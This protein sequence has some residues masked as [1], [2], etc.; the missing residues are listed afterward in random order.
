[1]ERASPNRLLM[2]YVRELCSEKYAGRLTGTKGY[3]DAAAW[4][5][6]R[7]ASWGLQP[8]GDNGTFCQEFPDP[9]T[10]VL[11]GRSFRLQVAAADGMPA[12]DIL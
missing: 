8:A 12:K 6:G 4:V 3:D 5:A 11:P 10:L 7:L 2:E 9:Y 1:M